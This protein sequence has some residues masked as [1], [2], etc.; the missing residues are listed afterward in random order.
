MRKCSGE[1][2][3][4]RSP[5][6]DGFAPPAHCGLSTP[7]AGISS[8]DMAGAEEPGHTPSCQERPCEPA[9]GGGFW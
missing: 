1:H 7:L 3:G 6:G 2:G 5:E 9:G 4:V 8:Q